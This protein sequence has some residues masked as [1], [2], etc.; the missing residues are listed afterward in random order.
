MKDF[1]LVGWYGV[2]APAGTPQAVVDAM[3][4]VILEGLKAADLRHRF[5]IAGLETYPASAS[6]LTR[7]G[8]T[9]TAKWKALVT[10]A[11]IQPE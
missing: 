4:H 9:E 10:N 1:E 11:G 8:N 6:E 5:A 2:Y 7:F 3:S